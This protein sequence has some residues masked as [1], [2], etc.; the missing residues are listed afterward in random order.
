MLLDN[1]ATKSNIEDVFTSHLIDNPAIEH[2]DAIFIYWAG[3]GSSMLAPRS[4]SGS[5]SFKGY[6][7][8]DMLVTYDHETKSPSGSGRIAGISDRSMHAMISALSQAKGDNITFALDASFSAPARS[9]DRGSVRWTPTVKATADDV[10][11]GLWRAGSISAGEG[12]F[13]AEYE[14]HTLLAASGSRQSAFEGNDGGRFTRALI[15]SAGALSLHQTSY[16]DLISQIISLEP[17]FD[18]NHHQT[19]RSL[20]LHK[21]RIIF[22]E[23][24]FIADERYIALDAQAHTSPDHFRIEMGSEHGI[25]AGTE[26]SMHRHNRRGSLNPAL[27]S[28]KVLEV[29]PTWSLAR[30]RSRDGVE[31]QWAQIMH[32][33]PFKPSAY[34]R[35]HLPFGY[36]GSQ[37]RSIQV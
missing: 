32:K 24:P 34:L 36:A 11:T 7:H 8:V 16:E 13:H 15:K 27:D 1:E 21:S 14:T 29:H 3:H 6:G 25:V 18:E 19:P 23:I 22:H 30:R 20:G 26:L 9:R 5:S 12:F 4:W 28:L 2:G 31:G 10:T 35:R 17:A 33:T 37:I